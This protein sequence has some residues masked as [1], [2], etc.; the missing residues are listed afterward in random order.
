MTSIVFLTFLGILGNLTKKFDGMKNIALPQ[1]T[2]EIPIPVK[3]KNTRERILETASLLF[4]EKGFSATS[5][6]D[7]LQNVNIAKG[8]FYHHFISKEALLESVTDDLT[9]MGYS[10]I[11]ERM[12]STKTDNAIAKLNSLFRISMEWRD[13]NIESMMYLIEALCKETNISLKTTLK[14]KSRKL[15][16]PLFEEILVEGKK[17]GLFHFEEARITA[18]LILLILEGLSDHLTEDLLFYR[19]VIPVEK[20]ISEYQTS[21][22]RILG[23][24]TN[25][26]RLIDW[27][28][29]NSIKKKVREF[30]NLTK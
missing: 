16:I 2:A 14:L 8:T 10:E 30:K 20:L 3:K 27:N 26:I 6:D 9:R 24:E 28:S 21:L 17:A 29:Y 25:T 12:R 18:E 22:E 7:I 1:E 15:N 13:E 23:L 5:I 19:T 4:M 11:I